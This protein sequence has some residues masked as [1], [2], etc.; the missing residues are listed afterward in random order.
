[1]ASIF[2]VGDRVRVKTGEQARLALKNINSR[3]VQG[4][5]YNVKQTESY[6]DGWGVRLEEDCM[7]APDECFELISRTYEVGQ[8]E[9]EQTT[10]ERQSPM[11]I[12]VTILKT[13]SVIGQQ[14]GEVETIVVPTTGVIANDNL[15]AVAQVAA[16]NAKA[17]LGLG[18]DAA[19][20][21]VLAQNLG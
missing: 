15:A 7:F 1:M 13:P 19:K 20:L 4:N 9:Q 6:K 3:S 10:K 12:N 16:T 21:R 5:T 18:P 8:V 11:L 14:A 17:I 2:Q